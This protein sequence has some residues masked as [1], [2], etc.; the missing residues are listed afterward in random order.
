MDKSDNL[1]FQLEPE[2]GITVL[3]VENNKIDSGLLTKMVEGISSKVDEIVAVESLANCLKT[4]EQKDFDVVLLDL[5]LE[6][7]VG[8]STIHRIKEKR[9]FL[10]VVIISGMEGDE[11]ENDIV[12]SGAQ[13]YLHKGRFNLRDLNKTIRFAIGRVKTEEKLKEV[14]AKLIQSE[15]MSSVG[16]LAAGVAHELNNPLASILTNLHMIAE[17]PLH[18]DNQTLIEVT[19]KS[20]KKCKDI[21]MSLLKYSR[22]NHIS[23]TKIVNIN[24]VIEEAL[25]LISHQFEHN[26]VELVKNLGVVDPVKVNMDE[27]QHVI[28]NLLLNAK[29]AIAE[30]G[31]SGKIIIKTFQGNKTVNIVIKDNGPGIPRE[32]IR[33]IFDPFYST[34]DVNK[35]TGLGLFTSYN[36]IRGFNG[37][38]DVVSREGDGATFTVILPVYED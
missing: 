16:Q 19:Q 15:K 29:D 31:K 38:L 28:T 3:I 34:K 35:G 14:N 11:I 21:V 8:V 22:G 4:L 37:H 30:S 9:P 25:S 6:D 12:D 32:D 5:N 26:G 27:L 7:S 33:K 1:K 24:D 17:D 23:D 10:P 20:A 2:E 18:E 13:D 36:I